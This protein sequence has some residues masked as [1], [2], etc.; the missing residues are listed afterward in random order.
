[1]IENDYNILESE[2]FK[3]IDGSLIDEIVKLGSYSQELV[4]NSNNW[5]SSLKNYLVLTH[6]PTAIKNSRLN[7]LGVLV[8]RYYWLKKFYHEYSHSYGIDVGIEQQISLL[9]E[10]IG[11][12]FQDFDWNVIQKIDQGIESQ[13]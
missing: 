2:Y 13:A 7:E 3:D 5:S 9:I 1:M 10:V 6:K 12:K 8:N 11:N 4:Y